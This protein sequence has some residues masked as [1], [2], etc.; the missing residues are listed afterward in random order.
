MSLSTEASRPRPGVTSRLRRVVWELR[1]EGVGPAR[2]AAAIGLGVFIGC[3]PLYG[4]HLLLCLAVGWCLGLNR[5]KM[6]LASNISNPFVAPFL[7]LTELQ[8]GAWLRRDALHAL[9]LDAVRNVD[10]WSFGADLIVGSLVV[11]GVLGVLSGTATYFMSRA[12]DD[13]P[14]FVALVHRAA[15]RYVST[16]ITAWEF[17]RGKLRGD[18]LYRTVL[19]EC[20]LPSG[21]ILVDVGCGQGLML[22]LLA[23]C[24]ASWRAG[25]WSSSWPAPAVFDRLV[26]IETRPRVAAIARQALGE[27]AA[28]VEGDARTHV[29]D[30]AR[31]VLFFDV[32]HMMPADDQEQLLASTATRLEAGGMILI[33]EPDA[34][35]RW[36]FAAVRAGNTAKAV[37]SGNWRQTFHFR[38]V[39]EWTACFA[40]LGFHVDVRGAGQGTPF[41][42]VLFVLTTLTTLTTFTTLTGSAR[43]SA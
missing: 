15:D 14:W 11:G 2:E 30:G 34:G 41:A 37:L 40:R 24:E 13:D 21:G 4:F 8:T 35:A 33:R 20:A 25:T 32:L 18:P 42:N 9:T 3:S 17:A 43:D 39:K 22:A 16:S 1:T 5:L 28:I 19:T 7:I 10:P 38:T 23:E 27:A 31:V 29:P 26:G 36:R 6:Y 12:G